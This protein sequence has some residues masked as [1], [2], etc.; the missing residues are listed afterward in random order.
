VTKGNPFREI[1]QFSKDETGGFVVT[2]RNA[3]G[4]AINNFES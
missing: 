2:E 1:A 3:R 4:A